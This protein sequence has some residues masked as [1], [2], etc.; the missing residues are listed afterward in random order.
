MK[1]VSLNSFYKKMNSKSILWLLLPVKKEELAK[2]Q[3]IQTWPFI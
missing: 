1:V 3:L 2:Q